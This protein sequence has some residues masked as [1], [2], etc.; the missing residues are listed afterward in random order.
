M[1]TLE[2]P[3]RATSRSENVAGRLQAVLQSLGLS[4]VYVAESL[5]VSR[6][7]INNVVH[8]RKPPSKTLLR[9]LLQ[10]HEVSTDW[11]LYGSGGMFT[12]GQA[13]GREGDTGS[14]GQPDM[15]RIRRLAQELA[16][17]VNH[18]PAARNTELHALLDRALPPDASEAQ[19]GRIR[20]FLEALAGPPGTGGP[21]S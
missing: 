7:Y 4:Q 6:G 9:W 1:Y 10:E 14:T 3:L 17:E 8:G 19:R 15:A 5:N 16:E 11:V 2:Y 18:L 20:G 21:G 12:Q 13:T